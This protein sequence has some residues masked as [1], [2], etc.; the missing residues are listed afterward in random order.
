MNQLPLEYWIYFQLGI[1]IALIM[2]ILFFLR[3]LRKTLLVNQ[4]NRPPETPIPAQEKNIPQIDTSSL[5][6]LKSLMESAKDSSS[7]F[8]RLIQEKKMLIAVL[9]EKLEL[10][11]REFI[12][13]IKKGETV[14]AELRKAIT[15]SPESRCPKQNHDIPKSM[16]HENHDEGIKDKETENKP[17]Q[18][19]AVMMLAARGLEPHSISARLGMPVGEVEL[20]MGLNKIIKNETASSHG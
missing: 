17:D 10:K 7:E 9:D 14:T 5:D 19:D 3:H 4:E 11:K 6:I 18:T 16:P 2:L 8:D 1:D 15:E 20:I 12:R 13:I